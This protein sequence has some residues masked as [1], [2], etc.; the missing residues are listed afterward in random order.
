MQSIPLRSKKVGKRLYDLR[1]ATYVKSNFYNFPFKM[2][3]SHQRQ[4]RSLWIDPL[5]W[6]RGALQG[7]TGRQQ[8]RSWYRQQSPISHQPISEH[9]FARYHE[10]SHQSYNYNPRRLAAVICQN[11]QRHQH[12]QSTSTHSVGLSKLSCL[13]RSRGEWSDPS[14]SSHFAAE[15]NRG[16]WVHRYWTL[17]PTIN[18]TDV[19]VNPNSYSVYVKCDEPT[20]E[21]AWIVRVQLLT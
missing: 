5:P 7:A 17:R 14:E 16:A 20:G 13:A 10:P 21:F 19:T 1:L 4:S 15:Y 8:H 18:C 12:I 3:L 2:Q 6:S 11:Y 9:H